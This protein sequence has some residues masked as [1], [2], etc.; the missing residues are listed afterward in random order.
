MPVLPKLLSDHPS[1]VGVIR[2]PS[3]V[4][5]TEEVP[6][7]VI[8]KKI[9]TG[10]GFQNLIQIVDMAT[11][12]TGQ[13]VTS[14][15]YTIPKESVTDFFP[16]TYYVLTDGEC[17]PLIMYPQYMR[18]SLSIKGKFAL[19]NQPIERYYPSSYKNDTSGAI[20]NITNT[21]QMSL[22]TATNEGMAF[23]NAN[24]NAVASGRK[25]Q[26]TGN[27]LNGINVVAS[28]VTTGGASLIGGGVTSV[29][30]G[31]SELKNA[32]A[33]AKDLTLTPSTISSFGTPSTREKFNTD[34]VR[35]IRYSVSENVKNKIKSF[36][37]R[38]G[39]KYNN[40]ATIDLKTYKGYV[41]FL[42]PKVDSKI[43]TVYLNKILEILERGVFV[44]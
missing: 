29:I 16:Y 27:I 43:D 40:Y 24:S 17:E 26:I 39:N 15:V 37:D 7:P 12:I 22:P 34:K 4:Y 1:L 2:F 38:Y 44:E 18:S 9:V 19:S 31:I 36:T 23:L 13:D 21:N 41:K 6:I 11:S 3:C 5:T 42:A 8:M 35:L 14:G 25:A 30:G 33:R 20:Y 32:D 10:D 28:A